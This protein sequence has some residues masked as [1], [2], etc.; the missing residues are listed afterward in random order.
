[1]SKWKKEKQMYEI[2]QQNWKQNEEQKEEKKWSG[3]SKGMHKRK[4]IP[5]TNSCL[6]N[7]L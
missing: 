5:I 7:R 2:K 1:M 4:A 3:L 6:R